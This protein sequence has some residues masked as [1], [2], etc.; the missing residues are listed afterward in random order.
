LE[1]GEEKLGL[2]SKNH[3]AIW[4]AEDYDKTLQ[5]AVTRPPP[6]IGHLEG[7][8]ASSETGLIRQVFVFQRAKY[9]WIGGEETQQ[10]SSRDQ[11]LT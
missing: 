5:G 1:N 3:L 10:R 8:R 6:V 7:R 2:M 4:A 9:V 11:G